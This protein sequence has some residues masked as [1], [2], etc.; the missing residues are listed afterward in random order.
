VYNRTAKKAC[1]L[2]ER[3]AQF[4]AAPVFGRP[5]AAAAMAQGWTRLLR[6]DSTYG[7]A[8]RRSRCVHCGATRH[9]RRRLRGRCAT[10]GTTRTCGG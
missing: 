2:A 1:P 9:A 6:R 8:R 10:M 5:A 4:V 7:G 3:G